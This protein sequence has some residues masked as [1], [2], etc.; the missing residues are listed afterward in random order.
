MSPRTTLE[1]ERRR[2]P[3]YNGKFFMSYRVA[4]KNHLTG[5][6]HWRVVEVGLA[7]ATEEKKNDYI[8]AITK[9]DFPEEFG[10]LDAATAKKMK[11]ELKAYYQTGTGYLEYTQKVRA[12]AEKEAEHE[13]KA[14]QIIQRSVAEEFKTYIEDCKSAKAAWDKLGL[15]IMKTD[16]Q[17]LVDETRK[18]WEDAKLGK[19]SVEEYFRQLHVIELEMKALQQPISKSGFITK[20]LEGLKENN[21]Y[22]MQISS[23]KA[24]QGLTIEHAKQVIADRE[25]EIAR[26]PKKVLFEEETAY[27]SFEK[28]DRNRSYRGRGGFRGSSRGARKGGKD[29]SHIQCYSCQQLGHFQSA[30]PNKQE[31]NS[32]TDI[33]GIVSAVLSNLGI[34]PNNQA[35]FNKEDQ[36]YAT[37]STDHLVVDSGATKTFAVDKKWFK[38]YE[39]LTRPI[40]IHL[41]DKKNHVLAIGYGDI[42]VNTKD[43]DGNQHVLKLPG[44][45]HV[46]NLKS[47]LLSVKHITKL[48]YTVHFKDEGGHINDQ[49]GRQ[50]AIMQENSNLYLLPHQKERALRTQISDVSEQDVEGESSGAPETPGDPS[51]PRWGN[52]LINVGSLV[53]P[54]QC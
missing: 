25:K 36:Q 9:I 10:P 54:L 22:A 19:Q 50:V 14:L 20:F 5:E 48:G 29:R 49:T 47:S 44:A 33:E 24:Q 8:Q 21:S 2:I 6:G 41:A 12:L 39:T 23:L 26:E 30:C 46:P 52:S 1:D 18:T 4:L 35:D 11:D 45:L 17:T 31:A 37:L 7:E 32:A 53:L 38:R 13:R 43:S 34:S 16:S 3:A 42:E 40:V 28:T 51:H 27:N 15:S